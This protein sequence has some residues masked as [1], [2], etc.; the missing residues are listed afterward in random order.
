MKRFDRVKLYTMAAIISANNLVP[1][2]QFGVNAQAAQSSDGYVNMDASSFPYDEYVADPKISL[3]D[4]LLE[5]RYCFICT[6]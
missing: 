1:F 4:E 6:C 5:K 2:A 3:Y